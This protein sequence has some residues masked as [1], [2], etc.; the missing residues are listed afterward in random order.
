MDTDDYSRQLPMCS[1]GLHTS[2]SLFTVLGR[3]SPL[4]R[5]GPV[6]GNEEPCP[7]FVGRV[8]PAPAKIQR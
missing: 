8:I 4:A 2:Q 6:M 5:C 7:E 1:G 3:S